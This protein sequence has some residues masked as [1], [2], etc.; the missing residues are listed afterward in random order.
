MLFVLSQQPA[1]S[2][3]KYILNSFSCP[4]LSGASKIEIDIQNGN[5]KNFYTIYHQRTIQILIIFIME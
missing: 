2:W 5:F 3:A 1:V 4:A